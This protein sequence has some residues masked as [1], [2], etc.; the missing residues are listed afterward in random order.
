MSKNI[1]F[2]A[3][4]NVNKEHAFLTPSE[5]DSRHSI[6]ADFLSSSELT[7]FLF[8]DL[9]PFPLL[10]PRLFPVAGEELVEVGG[11]DESA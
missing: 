6:A 2:T 11:V 7:V 8:S 4:D 10:R 9:R 3:C 1:F 5:T